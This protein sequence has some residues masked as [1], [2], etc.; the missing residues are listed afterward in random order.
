M[1]LFRYLAQARY[2]HLQQVYHIFGYLE[3]Y[4]RSKL[5]FDDQEPIFNK[6][7][8]HKYNWKE[9]YPDAAE[10]LPPD[11]LVPLGKA[12]VMLCFVD[13]DHAGCKEMRRSHTGVIIYVNKAPIIW[14]S[15]RQSTVKTSTFGSEIVA[16]K[17]VIKIIEGL[18]YKLRMLGVPINGPCRVFCDNDSFVKNV[19]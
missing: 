18:R 11:M 7:A 4:I 1:L 3:Q 8:F 19:S 10:V 14:Y 12:I 9:V 15:K 6:R 5:V 13:A 2:G 16:M 17:T